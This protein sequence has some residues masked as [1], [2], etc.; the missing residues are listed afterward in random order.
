V[1]LNS[2]EWLGSMYTL[3]NVPDHMLRPQV[4]D[5]NTAVGSD[6]T[7]TIAVDPSQKA[8]KEIPQQ[9]NIV[10]QIINGLVYVGRSI[11]GIFHAVLNFIWT[12]KFY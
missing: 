9:I 12:L 7:I 10:S 11:Y 3:M 5:Q 8:M 6:Q 2:E 4:P 1:Y